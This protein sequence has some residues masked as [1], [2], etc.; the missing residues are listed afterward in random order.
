MPIGEV[1]K[2]CIVGAGTMGCQ[3]SLLCAIHGYKSTLFDISEE[4]LQGTPV[5]QKEIAEGLVA[6]GAVSPSEV[7]AGL[8]R[9]TLTTDPGQAAENTDLLSESVPESLDLKRKVHAQFDQLCPPHTIMTTNTSTLLVSEIEGSVRRGDRFAALHFHSGLGS[10]V[11]IMRGPRTSPETV[12]ILKR[13][14]RSLGEVPMVMKK[15]KGGYLYNT[16]LGAL[17]RAALSLVIGGYAEV[18]D[19]DRAYMLVTKLPGGPFGGM[20]G[21]GLDVGLDC[22]KALFREESEVSKQQILDFLR[23]YVERGD[24]GVKTG[25][26]FYNYPN[27]T[28]QQ[29][30]FLT[31]QDS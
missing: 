25:K 8:A 6:Q 22:G 23:P 29:P 5:R 3:I 26:G 10:L 16:M 21:V 12:D 18:E 14:T 1:R 7:D 30:D 4:A 17:V 27:P 28:F 11:D 20:D 31:G 19:V 15:E 2:V 13:F 9:I 24:L